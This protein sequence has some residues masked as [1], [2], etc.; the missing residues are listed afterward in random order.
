MISGGKQCVERFAPDACKNW[1]INS[2][3][4][5]LLNRNHVSEMQAKV[6]T[7]EDV[8]AIDCALMLGTFWA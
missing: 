4:H 5:P 6:A 2:L 8:I 7:L 3:D 1:Y